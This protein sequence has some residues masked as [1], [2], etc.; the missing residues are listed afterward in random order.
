MALEEKQSS[1]FARFFFC[2]MNRHHRDSAE[3]E[4]E[5]PEQ[6]DEEEQS[7]W[8]EISDEDEDEED[9]EVDEEEEEEEGDMEEAVVEIHCGCEPDQIVQL[10]E[11][12]R[13]IESKMDEMMMLQVMLADKQAKVIIAHLEPILFLCFLSIMY[14]MNMCHTQYRYFWYI[15]FAVVTMPRMAS[16]LCDPLCSQLWSAKLMF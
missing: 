11:D 16:R 9:E 3:L 1:N 12:A 8:V 2:K 7:V 4:P 13:R 15:L 6:E 5:I 14:L 10:Q